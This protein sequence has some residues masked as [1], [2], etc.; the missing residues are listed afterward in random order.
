MSG[1]KKGNTAPRVT[2]LAD[3]ALVTILDKTSGA[4]TT[5]EFGPLKQL[6]TDSVFQKVTFT[7]KANTWYRI[8]SSVPNQS[9]V[10]ELLIVAKA[11]QQ[12]CFSAKWSIPRTSYFQKPQL[13]LF[14]PIRIASFELMPML[15]VCQP[16]S[17]GS[18]CHID[19]YFGEVREITVALSGAINA[20]INVIENPTTSNLTIHEYDLNGGG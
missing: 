6:I 9:T 15:R 5:I 4:L 2:A 3:D 8:M 20:S 11:P 18:S 17:S 10:G 1:T 19:V 12:E 14:N 7:C 16:S 13:Q